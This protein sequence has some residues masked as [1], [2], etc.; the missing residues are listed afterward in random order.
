[1]HILD[2]KSYNKVYKVLGG[3]NMNKANGV[4]ELQYNSLVYAITHLGEYRDG[5][6]TMQ[7]YYFPIRSLSEAI[8]NS[9]NLYLEEQVDESGLTF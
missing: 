1:M 4:T 6:S 5:V 9:D 7:K 2:K 8:N 3:E